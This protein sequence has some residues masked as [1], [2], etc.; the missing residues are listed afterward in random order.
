[1]FCQGT[2]APGRKD[3]ASTPPTETALQAAKY[4]DR[5][6]NYVK[7]GKF[8]LVIKALQKAIQLVPQNGN[9]YKNL[10]IVYLQ[11]NLP[12]HAVEAIRN[13]IRLNPDDADKLPTLGILQ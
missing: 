5:A 6:N 10:A 4:F 1:M 9:I 8:A 12:G 11:N 2:A 3:L 13:T 7:D